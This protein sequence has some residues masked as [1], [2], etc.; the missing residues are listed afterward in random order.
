MMALD[1]DEE[2]LSKERGRGKIMPFIGWEG[3]VKERHDE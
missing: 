1:V 2:E 3:I